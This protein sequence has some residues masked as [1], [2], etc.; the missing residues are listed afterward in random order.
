MKQSTEDGSPPDRR[1]SPGMHRES[2]AFK[3]G[4]GGAHEEWLQRTI[5]TEIVPRLMLAH[6]LAGAGMPVPASDALLPTEADV[7]SL[8][9]M[10]LAD[11]CPSCAGFIET[12]RDRGIGLEPLFL[13]LLAPT[14][15]L[16]GVMWERDQCDFTQVTLGLWRLQNLLFDLSPDLQESSSDPSIAPHRAMFASAPGSQHTLGLLMVSEFFR[17]AGW[18]VWAEQAA[19]LDEMANVARSDWFDLIG[20]SASTDSHIAGVTSAIRTL[21]KAS[22]NPDVGVMVGGPIFLARPELVAVVGADFTA[23]DARQAVEAASVFAGRQVG[24]C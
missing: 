15:R 8:A 21:R 7:K 6:R 22:R 18:D 16:L 13:D 5:E 17:R 3:P 14:A 20:L 2:A 9:A 11:D 24:R 19:S 1:G 23:I 12:L 10:I 4:N